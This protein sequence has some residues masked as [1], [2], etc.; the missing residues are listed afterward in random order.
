M[1]ANKV[2]QI[3]LKKERITVTLAADGSATTTSTNLIYGEIFKITYTKSTGIAATTTAAVTANTPTETLDSYNV[4]SGSASHYVA[5]KITASTDE[6]V[7]Y[8]VN[9]Y[10]TVTVASGQ[11]GGSVGLFYVDIYYR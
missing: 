7:R 11:N 5:T 10:V 3:L 6:Y 8:I 9:D 4:N 2:V 1:S